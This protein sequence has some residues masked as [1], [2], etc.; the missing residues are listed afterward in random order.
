MAVIAIV[1]GATGGLGR[2]FVEEIALSE[3]I[4]EIW[5]VGRNAEKLESLRKSCSKVVP[6]E[7]DLSSG[8]CSRIGELLD[9]KRPEVRILVNN[10]GTAYMGLFEEMEE[11]RVAELCAINCT[12]PAVLT[13]RV[14]PYMKEGARI[15]N[16]SSA[17]SFQPNPYLTMYSASKVFLTNFSRALGEELKPRKI[18]VTAVCPGWVDTGMLP[19]KKDGKE[20]R[21][22]GMISPEQVV[23]VALKDSAGGR[24]LSLP[25]FFA[26]YFSFYSK[27]MPTRIVMRQWS[28]SVRKYV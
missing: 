13:R 3:E 9:Q 5:A 18:T 1:T 7:E 20:I 26:K 4:D 23:T 6:V 2:K 12:A 27:V 22:P 8:K 16:I 25:G 10:A 14:L 21:Y 11:E 15:L 17:S 19:R 28:R 24:A